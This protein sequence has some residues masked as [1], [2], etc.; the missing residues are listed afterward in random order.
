M[1]TK[2][3][4][5]FAYEGNSQSNV[6]GTQDF[7]LVQSIEFGFYIFFVVVAGRELQTQLDG[8][9]GWTLLRSSADM[10]REKCWLTR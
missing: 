9:L 8:M 10:S 3:E 2:Q 4:R 5:P 7:D 6:D 1:I